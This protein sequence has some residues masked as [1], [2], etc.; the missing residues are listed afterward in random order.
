LASK[1]ASKQTVTLFS[2]SHDSIDDHMAL[3]SQSNEFM[4]R[5]FLALKI[6]FCVFGTETFVIVNGIGLIL[7]LQWQAKRLLA[8]TQQMALQINMQLVQSSG[9]RC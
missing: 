7:C 1:Q 8:P 4:F 5:F 3:T 2:S 9:K 6:V